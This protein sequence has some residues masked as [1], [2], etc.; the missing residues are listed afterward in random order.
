MTMPSRFKVVRTDRELEMPRVDDQLRAWGG[1]L[2]L[3]PDRTPAPQ[4][5][6]ALADADLLLMCYAP[7]TRAMIDGAARLKAIIKYGVGIDAIDIEAARERGVPVVNVPAYAEET[8]AEGAF[9]LLLGLF[10]R[11]GRS[12]RRCSSRAGSGPS[13]AGW[14]AT[15]RAKPWVCWA[16]GASAAAWRAW[17]GAFA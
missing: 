1:E 3:L 15:C 4:L 9:A 17:R 6:Q 7:I 2:L 12:S 14:P 13:R 8:V 11:F 5:A 10:K 16:W